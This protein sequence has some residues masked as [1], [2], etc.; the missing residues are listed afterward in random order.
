MNTVLECLRKY[1]KIRTYVVFNTANQGPWTV[2]IP[3]KIPIN[4][5]LI[6]KNLKYLMSWMGKWEI[7]LYFSS[8]NLIFLPIEK[9]VFDK[10]IGLSTDG[11][12]A[13]TAITHNFTQI[14]MECDWY[15]ASFSGKNTITCSKMTLKNVEMN[16]AQFQIRMDIMEML[17]MKY[18]NEKPLTFP[19][20]TIQIA[21]F[22]GPP[23]KADGS[24][25]ALS[26]VLCQAI[27]NCDTLFVLPFRNSL[28]HTVCTNPYVR[29]LQLHAGEYGSYPTQPFSTYASD[30]FPNIRFVNAVADALNVNSSELTS[31]S[32][33]IART[34]VIDPF[35][36]TAVASVVYKGENGHFGDRTNFFIPFPFS[37]NEDFQGGLSSPSSNI[38]FKLTGDIQ[39]VSAGTGNEK[40][41]LDGNTFDTP[42]VACFL[43]DGVIMIRPDPG[44]DAAK[45]I[46]SDRTVA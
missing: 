12:A 42:W 31:F 43:I 26:I 2:K 20:S 13:D 36:Q 16:T 1:E 3:I 11:C 32:K 23:P 39:K 22:T 14:G 25:V 33:D 37:T 17:K 19:V 21:R 35:I 45:V 10:V 40:T 38:N 5:F 4:N 6:L 9:S 15:A 34:F 8:Q 41:V 27:N 30:G 7:R 46:W 18:M 24:N 28:Q 44:S 29:E